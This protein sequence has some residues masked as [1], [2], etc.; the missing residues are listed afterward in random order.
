M[1]PCIVCGGAIAGAAH[2]PCAWGCDGDLRRLREETDGPVCF[3]C[4]P[5]K[6]K[7]GG[8]GWHPAMSANDLPKVGETLPSNVIARRQP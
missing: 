8:P 1:G 2:F 3:D 6:F 5:A 7:R 4:L